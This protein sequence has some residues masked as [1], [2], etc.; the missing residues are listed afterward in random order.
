MKHIRLILLILAGL[1]NPTLSSRAQS[2]TQDEFLSQLKQ[3]HPLFDKE[4][5]TAQ[6]EKEAQQSLIGS[7]DWNILSS[8]SFA[9]EEPAIPIMGPDRTDALSISGGIE[10]LFWKT[11]GRFSTSYSFNRVNLKINPSLGIPDLYYQNQLAFTYIHPLLQ[12]RNGFLDRFQYGLRQFD[13]NVAE[14]Q[15]LENQESFLTG[16]AIKFLEWVFLTEQEK[17]IQERLN[18]SNESLANTKKKRKANLVDEVDVLRAEDAVRIAKQNL[19]LVESQRKSLQAELAVLSQNDDLHNLN[20]EFNLYSGENL[21]P[22]DEAILQLKQNS[23]LIRALDIRIQQLEY[24]RLGFEETR[25][26]Q[27]S[28]LAQFNIKNA[29]EKFGDALGMD[30]PDFIGGLQF[31]VPLE[32]RTAKSNIAKTDLQIAQLG[33]Q[34]EEFII[35]LVA[36]LSNLY[37][38]I[39]ELKKILLLNQEQ[40]ESAKAKTAEEL[41]L[42]NRGRVDLTFVIQSQDGEQNARLTY[43]VNALTYHKLLLEYRALMDQLL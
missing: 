11:G 7:Q 37:I 31:S 17:I 24:S 25:K 16:S 2:I 10:K 38:Q 14:I 8:V 1:V 33:Q 34:R 26:P 9:H 13:I 29:D 6:I 3:V 20:P 41:K 40:I 35:S 23:R 39:E 28:L 21:P 19:V 27:L 32:K 36:A 43:A 5:L 30:K 12:N 4:S 18:L 22:Q 42:Y 15:A